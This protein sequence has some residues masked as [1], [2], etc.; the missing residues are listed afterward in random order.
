MDVQTQSSTV[1]STADGEPAEIPLTVFDRYAPRYHVSVLFAFVPPMPPNSAIIEGL[2]RTLV[3]FPT[4]TSR[5]GTSRAN[6]PCLLVGGKGGGALVVEAAVAGK[7]ADWMPLQPGPELERLCPPW[8][9]TEV[10]LLIF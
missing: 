4:L 9:D 10:S 1:I 6:R 2:A 7:L 3:H 5:I 8:K